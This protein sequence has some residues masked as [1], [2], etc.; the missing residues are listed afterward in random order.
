MC[1]PD[2][3]GRESGDRPQRAAGGITLVELLVF[4]VIVSVGLAGVLGV[5]NTVVRRSAD[6]LVT[7]QL[8]A[9]AEALL[10]EVQLMP[11]TF[12][13][14]DDP[15]AATATSTA[16][17][18]VVE[19]LG[20]EG[21]ETRGGNITPLDNVS[22]YRLAGGP[23]TIDPL[24]DIAGNAI[25]GLAGYSASIDVQQLSLNGIPASES[26]AITVTVSGPGGQ[27]FALSGFRTR[28]SPRSVP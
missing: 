28:Y 8:T 1:I 24:T 3:A 20:P 25:P 19:G 9:V 13:D 10:E 17:C 7:K 16:S 6:P 15:N 12:C 21:A 22:D 14:P 18:T 26:L 2:R 27:S 11:F 23:L 4:I 5:F